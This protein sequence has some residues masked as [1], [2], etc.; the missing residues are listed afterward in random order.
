MTGPFSV[1]IPARHGSSRLPGKPLADIAG[2]PMVVRVAEQVARSGASDTLVA[3]DH[4]A[5]VEAVASH[6]FRAIMTSAAHQS[7]SDR[8]MEV[9]A[10]LGWSDDHVV[11]NVQGDEPLVPPEVIDQ[12]AAALHRTP[13]LSVATL[14]EPLSDRRLLMDPNVV[15]VVR[16]ADGRALYFSRAPVPWWRDAFTPQTLPQQDKRPL[17]VPGWQRHIGIYGFRVQALRQFC[18]AGA[19][20]LEGFEALEQLRMLEIGLEIMVEEAAVPVPAGV[21]TAADLARVNAP[22]LRGAD[23]G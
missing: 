2:R 11:I 19:G 13:A 21:D 6:G 7:G 15:K 20:L 12:V 22:R 18:Q 1:V 3:T 17:P 14:C 10:R 5:I 4:A 16:R 9:A 23:D 8:V